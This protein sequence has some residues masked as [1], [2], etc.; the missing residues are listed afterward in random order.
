MGK[1]FVPLILHGK[2]LFEVLAM[3]LF[4]SREIL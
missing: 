4:S 2:T 3:P 1:I